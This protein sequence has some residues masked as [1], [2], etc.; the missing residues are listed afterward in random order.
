MRDYGYVGPADIRAEVV[1]ADTAGRPIRS[2]TDFATWVEA[3]EH[4]E[5]F[6]YVVGLDGVLR[7]APRRSEHVACAGGERVLG[8]GEIA[9]GIEA[10]AWAVVEVGNQSTGYCPEPGSWPAVAEALARI[11]V[12]HPEG[13]THEFVFRRCPGCGERNVVKEGDFVCACCEAE[14]PADWNFE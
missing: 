11:G 4:D 8:A 14:L 5:P 12:A 1:R 6:T 3:R 2:A 9:F 7:L 10:G 13:F